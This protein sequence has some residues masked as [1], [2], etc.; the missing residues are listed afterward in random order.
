MFKDESGRMDY[1][2]LWGLFHGVQTRVSKLAS[3]AEVNFSAGLA[4]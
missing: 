4:G 3:I 1:P 2:I